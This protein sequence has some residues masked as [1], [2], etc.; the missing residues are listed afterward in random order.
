LSEALGL[1]S[2]ALQSR[3]AFRL[4]AVAGEWLAAASDEIA[5]DQAALFRFFPAAGRKV[6]RGPLIEPGAH[7][8]RL[9][10]GEGPLLNPWQ[11]ADAARVVLL[12]ASVGREGA[13]TLRLAEELYDRGSGAERIA[14]LRGL[15]FFL[16]D[17][18]GLRCVRDALR[19]N[20]AD[21][22]AAAICE[23]LYAS[24]HLP[25]PIFFQAV[26]KCVFVGLA[27][28]RVERIEERC[29]PELS[30]M[31]FAY[32]TKREQ[33]GRPITPAIWPL[34]ALHPPP[35]AQERIAA[36]LAVA[37]GDD[38]RRLLEVALARAER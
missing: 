17:D 10:G 9:Q 20:A 16:E 29:A 2:E 12:L 33:A 18:S 5:R 13:E 19:A 30:R 32:A 25:D 37:A 28:D 7:P 14:V 23:N 34:I 36:L 15:Q 26:L 11:V 38:E 4:S 22:F 31:L 6:G 24:R 1:A 8:L 21:L 27:V 3:L 35:G